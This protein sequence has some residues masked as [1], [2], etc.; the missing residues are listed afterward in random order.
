MLSL[1]FLI[2]FLLPASGRDYARLLYLGGTLKSTAGRW[3]I[4]HHGQHY[5]PFSPP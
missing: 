4:Q 5:L 1:R 3:S 2:P